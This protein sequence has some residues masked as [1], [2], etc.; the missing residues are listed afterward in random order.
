[1]EMETISWKI[2]L[3]MEFYFD[4]VGFNEQ[5]KKN[6]IATYVNL[7]IHGNVEQFKSQVNNKI[8]KVNF[9]IFAYQNHVMI[10]PSHYFVNFFLTTSS[11]IS[12]TPFKK[13]L[14][15]FV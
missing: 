9:N 8:C 15:Y 2:Y 6:K 1:M 11:I 5:M 7:I 10:F 14:N 3:I 4:I 12:Q 13:D